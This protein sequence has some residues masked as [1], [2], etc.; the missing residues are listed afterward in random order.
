MFT[1]FT[2]EELL[3]LISNQVE[4]NIKLEYKGADSL[5]KSDPKK[6]EISKDVSAFANSDGGTLIY[7]IREFDD[8]LRRHLPERIDPIDRTNFSKEWLEQVINSNIQPKVSGL[9][10]TPIQ[11]PSSNNH[12]AY[13]VVI[14]KS[15]TAHQASDNK[16]Y[17]RYN[18]QSV[19][20]EDYEVKDNI[21]RQSNPVLHVVLS[22]MST[23]LIGNAIDVIKMP[24]VLM[25]SSVKM[26]KDVQMTLQINEPLNCEVVAFDNLNDLS[27]LNPGKRLF[28]SAHDARIYKGLNI[29]VGS[30]SIRLINT[31]TNVSF[32]SSVYA[33]NMDPMNDVIQIHVVNNEVHYV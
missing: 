5:Q 13:A 22:P 10:I 28:I 32:T 18:F 24:L 11:L 26:A 15:I 8:L 4:E 27:P 25:N 7:G 2:H 1:N 33:D 30:I 31:A 12:V 9:I 14:P 3:A 6:K 21:K 20:M 19:A 29:Q 17:K 23:S 16:Y